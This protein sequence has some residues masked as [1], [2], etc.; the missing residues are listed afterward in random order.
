M[1]KRA[2]NLVLAAASLMLGGLLYVLFRPTT[3]LAVLCG[4]IPIVLQIQMLFARHKCPVLSY[5]FVDFL[6]GLSLSS[7][8]Q[9]IH[10]PRK[11]G[12]IGFALLAFGWGCLW[13]VLQWL[14]VVSGTGDF[15]D[16]FMYFL[17]ALISI[18]INFKERKL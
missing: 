14:R 5:Y 7:G 13:E 4:Q 1:S 10:T 11:K 3:I 9:A 12:I 2:A 8:L 16:V 6:W 17:A 15:F 18:L